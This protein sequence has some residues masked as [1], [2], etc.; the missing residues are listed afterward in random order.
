[1]ES[2]AHQLLLRRSTVL[3]V[4]EQAQGKPS[5]VEAQAI[6]DR[7]LGRCLDLPG[8]PA[9]QRVWQTAEVSPCERREMSPDCKSFSSPLGHLEVD[10]PLERSSKRRVDAETLAEPECARQLLQVEV[11]AIGG[12]V[13]EGGEPPEQQCRRRSEHWKP[14]DLDV[15]GPRVVSDLI[16]DWVWPGLDSQ[17][18]RYRIAMHAGSG[19]RD[20]HVASRGRGERFI[21]Y[22]YISY[23]S[24]RQL[25]R[26]KGCAGDV[27]MLSAGVGFKALEQRVPSKGEAFDGWSVSGTC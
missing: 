4:V 17:Y 12:I 21:R 10:A 14:V 20:S 27:G 13:E 25:S 22:Q 26:I 2:P 18:R 8:V 6:A 5:T 24:T 1:M 16:D 9:L 23:V 11:D 3:A 15:R 19:T 7:A